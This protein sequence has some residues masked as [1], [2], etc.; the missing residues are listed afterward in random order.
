M[1]WKWNSSYDETESI[2]WLVVRNG[3]IVKYFS[4]KNL[5]E[6][7]KELGKIGYRI[8]EFSTTNWT[9]ENVHE[10]IREDFGFPDYYGENI[11]AFKDCLDDKFN[12]KYKG[13]V[14]VLSNFDSFY[15]KN[16]DFSESLMNAIFNVSWSWLLAEQKLILL[17]QSDDPNLVIDKVGGFEPDW[18]GEEWL[19]EKRQN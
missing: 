8:I 11:S 10:K 7:V 1:T 5:E 15:S 2:D 3:P 18:N 16:K 9:R 12:K 4:K 6:D 13:L 19:N 14:V 17:I